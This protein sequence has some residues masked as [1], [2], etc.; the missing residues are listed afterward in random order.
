MI[1]NISTKDV[2]GHRLFPTEALR[3]NVEIQMPGFMYRTL[4]T[5]YHTKGSVPSM[6]PGHTLLA[7]EVWKYQT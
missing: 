7:E 5:L 4:P 3:C 1:F 6:L 2:R